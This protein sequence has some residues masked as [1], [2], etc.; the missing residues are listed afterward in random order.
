ME[1][2][3][4]SLRKG[5]SKVWKEIWKLH[6]PNVEKTFFWHA[7]Q[8]IL[9]TRDNPFRRKI[10]ADLACLISGLDAETAVHFLWHC[11]S[12]Q[13]VWSEGKAK[14]QKRSFHGLDFLQVAEDMLSKCGTDI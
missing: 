4:G 9:P 6:I 7:C 11:S 13:D 1:K 14:F 5:H 3:I 12:A 10:L 8:D 2:G